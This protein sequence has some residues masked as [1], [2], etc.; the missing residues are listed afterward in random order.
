MDK[1]I[2]VAVVAT[3]AFGSANAQSTNP[4]CRLLD[5]FAPATTALRCTL[6]AG[7]RGTVQC[8]V[9][10]TT[11]IDAIESRTAVMRARHKGHSS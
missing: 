6:T 2:L 10:T 7:P 4:R 9:R 1:F 8:T 11:F 5:S 3:V